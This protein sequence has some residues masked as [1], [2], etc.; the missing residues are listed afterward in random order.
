M[1]STSRIR[2]SRWSGFEGP[3]DLRGSSTWPDR[4]FPLRRLRGR[5]AWKIHF[6]AGSGIGRTQAC[7]DRSGGPVLTGGAFAVLDGGAAAHP[8]GRYGDSHISGV[9]GVVTADPP[10]STGRIGIR[11]SKPSSRSAPIASC[12]VSVLGLC[13]GHAR[14]AAASSCLF[15]PL[16]SAL[17]GSRDARR[18]PRRRRRRAA[19]EGGAAHCCLDRAIACAF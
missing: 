11:S 8:L 2:R 10:S 14:P 19:L 13:C 17:A 9:Q 4:L 12:S 6:G 18:V 3:M 5:R 7:Q 16:S 15:A 1:I